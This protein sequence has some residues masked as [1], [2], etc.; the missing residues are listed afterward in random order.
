MVENYPG[1]DVL[2][3]K[4]YW[5]PKTRQV[6]EQRTSSVPEI[7]FFTRDEAATLRSAVLGLLPQK[8]GTKIPIIPFIDEKLD[9]NQTD[10]TRYEDIPRMQ[11]LWRMFAKALDEEA[12]ASYRR[13]FVHLSAKAQDEILEA[14]ANGTTRSE[15]WSKLPARK[16]FLQIVATTATY[17]YAH[18]YAWSEIGW[19][20]PKHPE[21]Y[22]RIR[23]GIKDPEEPG[24]VGRVRE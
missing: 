10:G 2:D 5:D 7:R 24:E 17:Y 19:G 11:D 3:R 15:T 23:C 13:K 9:K 14:L 22:V 21:S 18:P 8:R 20:G 1:Y 12:W 4:E 16:A 6:I